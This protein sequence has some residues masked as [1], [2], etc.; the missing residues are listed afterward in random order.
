MG[1]PVEGPAVDNWYVSD[2]D[3]VWPNYDGPIRGISGGYVVTECDDMI[4]RLNRWLL[5]QDQ[6]SAPP[7]VYHAPFEP[8]ADHNLMV[9][10]DHA[11]AG[12][13]D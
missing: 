4:G 3:L 12:A 2:T 11:R 6:T 1:S 7:R 13:D 8:R 10:W 5:E 9:G